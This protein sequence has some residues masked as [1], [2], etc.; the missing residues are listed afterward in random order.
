MNINELKTQLNNS[1]INSAT[2]N[3]N[4]SSQNGD[5]SSGAF[6]QQRQNEQKAQTEYN[7]FENEEA[8]EEIISSLEIIV[9]RYI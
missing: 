6:Q 3:F 4:S 5:N 7:H 9:P 8:H 1:G 2:F